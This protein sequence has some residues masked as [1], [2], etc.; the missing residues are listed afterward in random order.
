MY[1]IFPPSCEGAG[2]QTNINA[3]ASVAEMESETDETGAV[4][5]KFTL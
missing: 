4:L 2:T 3:G 5:A 1:Q